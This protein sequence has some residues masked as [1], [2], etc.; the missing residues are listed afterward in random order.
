MNGLSVV[1]GGNTCSAFCYL[2]EGGGINDTNDLFRTLAYRHIKR[3]KFRSDTRNSKFAAG[4]YHKSLLSSDKWI[5]RGRTATNAVCFNCNTVK[6][7]YVYDFGNI[8]QSKQRTFQDNKTIQFRVADRVGAA[9]I[10]N[11]SF[12]EVAA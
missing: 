2:F 7:K 9:S 12:K 11:A 6:R 1:G 5:Y 8:F 10:V 4:L 3:V